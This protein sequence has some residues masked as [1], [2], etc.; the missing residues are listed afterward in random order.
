[1]ARTQATAVNAIGAYVTKLFDI[2]SAN[3]SATE[4][5]VALLT[6]CT[7]V[8]ALQIV[9]DQFKT[10]YAKQYKER[11]GDAFDEA[12]CKAATDMAWS[13]TVSRATEAGYVKPVAEN[14]KAKAARESRAKK[15]EGKVDGRTQ[16][17]GSRAA[18]KSKAS[19]VIVPE[20]NGDEELQEAFDW[21]MED[22]TRQTLFIAWVESHKAGTRTVR[23]AA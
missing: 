16:R 15:S 14:A 18:N 5:A 12:K 1:M 13:R 11:I 3:A 8:D 21:V 4:M 23:R 19:D 7:T 20:T 17:T 2:Q 6:P 9:R 10:E 22:E